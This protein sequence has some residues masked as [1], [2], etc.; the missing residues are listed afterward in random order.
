MGARERHGKFGAVHCRHPAQNRL[1]AAL[2]RLPRPA[3]RALVA[4]LDSVAASLGL[5]TGPAPLFFEP[6]EEPGRPGRS[7]S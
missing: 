6:S 3:L 4:N 5:D 2:D 1:I 7:G